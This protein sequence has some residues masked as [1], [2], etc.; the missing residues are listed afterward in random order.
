ME[1][2]RHYWN[3]I[4]GMYRAITR[5]DAD[6]FHYGPLLAGERTLRLLPPLRPGMDALELGCGEGQNSIWL[7]RR[8]LRCT[9]ID[10]SEAQLAYARA[11]ARAAGL[12][13]AFHRAAIEDY[14]APEASFDLVTSSHAFEFLDDPFAQLARVA[15][16]LRPGGTLVYSTCTYNPDEDEAILEW[17]LSEWDAETIPLPCPFPG[18]TPAESP[19]CAFRFYPHKTAGE[20]FFI[21]A[22]RKTGGKTFTP[23]KPKKGKTGNITPLPPALKP[24]LLHPEQFPRVAQIIISQQPRVTPGSWSAELLDL[25]LDTFPAGLRPRYLPPREAA[26]RTVCD[27]GMV[28]AKAWETAGTGSFIGEPL[29]ADLL[30]AAAYRKFHWAFHWKKKGEKLAGILK[31]LVQVTFCANVIALILIPGLLYYDPYNLLRGARDFLSTVVWPNEDDVVMAGIIGVLLGW[32]GAVTDPAANPNQFDGNWYTAS[33]LGFVAQLLYQGLKS[34]A[35]SPDAALDALLADMT[36]EHFKLVASDGAVSAAHP[37]VQSAYAM[38]EVLVERGAQP[39]R[40]TARR[41][42]EDALNLLDP[43]RDADE[44]AALREQL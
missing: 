30:R 1:A 7:A 38:L 28:V 21:G 8:G 10:I 6:D 34:R 25:F 31:I 29:A 33:T 13:V 40:F 9:A 42:A 41:Y 5:I 23:R 16:W 11:D 18:V 2:Q 22:V 36:A 17:L 37:R 12:A 43:V 20:G 39:F 14:D 26:K 35:G 3:G 19:A 27:R 24:Y 32:F 4:A 15:R 44:L